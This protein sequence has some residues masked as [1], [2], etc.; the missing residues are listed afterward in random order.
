[1]PTSISNSSAYPQQTARGSP[2][3]QPCGQRGMSRA[4]PNASL[5]PP[6]DDEDPP[7][8]LSYHPALGLGQAA[9]LVQGLTV[10]L[11]VV[12]CALDAALV[13]AISC[14]PALRRKPMFCF[15]ASLALADLLRAHA[16]LSLLLF[17]RPGLPGAAAV[18]LSLSA[19]RAQLFFFSFTSS[20]GFAS[21]TSMLLDR[22]LA[23]CHPFQYL[24]CT[25]GGRGTCV[26]LA[27]GWTASLAVAAS[28]LGASLHLRAC[29]PPG[30]PEGGPSTRPPRP[31]RLP[32]LMCDH[33]SLAVASCHSSSSDVAFDSALTG[34]MST[35]FLLLSTF[36]YAKVMRASMSGAGAGERSRPGP[37]RR[38][39]LHTCW[40]HG[41]LLAVSYATGMA[42]FLLEVAEFQ[43]PERLSHTAEEELPPALRVVVAAKTVLQAANACGVPV[44]NALVYGLRSAELRAEVARALLRCR[45]RRRRRRRAVQVA[46]PSVSG[47]TQDAPDGGGEPRVPAFAT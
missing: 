45:H 14:L 27:V 17:A 22:Y 2:R 3:G 33:M 8:L 36:T 41:A 16:G 13:T 30:D 11:Y 31:P 7:Q 34:V 15:M 47:A 46:V 32:G 39:A 6:D 43:A 29:T 44:V 4:S 1:M 20:A 40:T 35:A 26:A 37:S 19:C 9:L 42:I 21:V 18:P 10:A 23:I 24:R 12:G 25:H 5:A 38:K 28:F